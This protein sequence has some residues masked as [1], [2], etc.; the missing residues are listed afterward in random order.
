MRLGIAQGRRPAGWNLFVAADCDLRRIF[1]AALILSVDNGCV[2]SGIGQALNLASR[3]LNRCSEKLV[4]TTAL[5]NHKFH[6]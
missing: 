4:K 1:S 5:M 3:R 2:L 6:V